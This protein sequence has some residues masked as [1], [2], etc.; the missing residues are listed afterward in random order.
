MIL[1]STG[2]R[3][4]HATHTYKRR[5]PICE[6]GMCRQTNYLRIG[7][8]DNALLRGEHRLAFTHTCCGLHAF[9]LRPTIGG[10]LSV[11]V[12]RASAGGAPIAPSVTGCFASRM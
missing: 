7:G 3:T 10:I 1:S 6:T 12:R 5:V 2:K 4:V 9:S 11:G 8:K